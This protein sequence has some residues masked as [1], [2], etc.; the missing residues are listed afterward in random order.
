MPVST[1]FVSYR[2]GSTGSGIKVALSFDAGGMSQQAFTNSQGQAVVEH[3]SIGRATVFVS[4]KSCGS[5]VAPG[6]TAVTI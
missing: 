3:S 5:F 4:G 1:I 2:D 6:R